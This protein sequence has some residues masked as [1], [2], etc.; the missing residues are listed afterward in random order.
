MRARPGSRQFPVHPEVEAARERLLRAF[1]G[2]LDHGEF[3]AARQEPARLLTLRH[4]RRL[5]CLAQR[6]IWH[7]RGLRMMEAAE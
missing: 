7:S 1:E 4:P 2:L 5:R 3:A 6:N